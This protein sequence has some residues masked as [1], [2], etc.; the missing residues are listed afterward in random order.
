MKVKIV[1]NSS[2]ENPKYET[3]GAAGMDLKADF[4]CL[5]DENYLSKFPH[6]GVILPIYGKAIDLEIEDVVRESI[7]PIEG[8]ILQPQARAIIPTNIFIQLPEDVEAQIRP[9]SGLSF[10]KGLTLTNSPGTI[11]E[12]Y[13][14]NIG[15]I[16]SNFTDKAIEILHGERIAQVV[17]NKIEKIEW[18]DVEELDTTTRGSGGFGHTGEK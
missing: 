12:D 3:V 13:R 8:I 11:D 14:G 4:A 10:K 6:I 18:E 2:F 7:L 1:N 5:N 9:R 15:I 17:F 16:V